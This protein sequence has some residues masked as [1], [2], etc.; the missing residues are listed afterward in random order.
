MPSENDSE[1]NVQMIKV[2]YVRT[3]E[4]TMYILQMMMQEVCKIEICKLYIIYYLLFAIAKPI[5]QERV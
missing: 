5:K 3:K 4:K 1:I 2:C